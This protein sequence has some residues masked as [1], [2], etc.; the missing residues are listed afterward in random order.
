MTN[1]PT[2]TS[3]TSTQQPYV[4]QRD[5]GEHLHFLNHLATPKVTAG[6]DGSMTTV[7]FLAP[8]G[9]GP[10]LHVHDSEDEVMIVLDGEIA[11][12]AG[13]TESVARAGATVYLPHGVPHTFQVTSET[14]RFVTVSA[15]KAGRP[16]FDRMVKTL[17][18]ATD[19]PSI[20]EPGEIDPGEVARVCGDHGIEVLG[21]PPAPLD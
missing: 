2:I 21:P 13:D 1:T 20:P 19:D 18:T 17:G 5:E 3:P 15:S 12:R 14:A 11:C 8:R 10:P 6:E 9:F 7:E 16:V 4:L